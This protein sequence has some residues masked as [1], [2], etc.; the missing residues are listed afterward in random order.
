MFAFKYTSQTHGNHFLRVGKSRDRYSLMWEPQM[1]P[2]SFLVETR[3]FN[4]FNLT[5]TS[6][7]TMLI[8]ERDPKRNFKS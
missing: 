6:P 2:M 1:T 7:F 5:N 3:T 4:K 8:L